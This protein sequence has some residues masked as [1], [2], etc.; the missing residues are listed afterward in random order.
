MKKRERRTVFYKL[1]LIGGGFFL[2]GLLALSASLP[3]KVS[4]THN[5]KKEVLSE[6]FSG[7]RNI[8][9]TFVA[10]LNNLSCIEVMLSSSSK[11]DGGNFF[12]YLN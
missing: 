6:E 5:L 8:G 10:E 9:Q 4:V 11:S 1:F 3:K 2:I 12:F 7:A